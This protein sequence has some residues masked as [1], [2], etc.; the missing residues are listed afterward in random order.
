VFG[1]MHWLSGS[2][3]MGTGEVAYILDVP[4][5]IMTI[6]SLAEKEGATV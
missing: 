2:T 3:I 6:E 5:M 4:R 1:N